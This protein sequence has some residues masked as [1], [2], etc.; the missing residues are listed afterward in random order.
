MLPRPPR[1]FLRPFV[2]LGLLLLVSVPLAQAQVVIKERV[3]IAPLRKGHALPDSL[4]N[5]LA[6]GEAVTAIIV[7]PKDG[8]LQLFYTNAERI[9]SP[10]PDSAFVTVLRNGEVMATDPVLTRFPSV[11]QAPRF[12]NTCFGFF[13]VDLFSYTSGANALFDIGEVEEGDVLN[14]LYTSGLGTFAGFAIQLNETT[15]N[16]D[17]GDFDPCLRTWTER[18]SFGVAVAIEKLTIEI[19]EPKEVWPEIPDG[20]AYRTFD[21]DAVEDMIEEVVIE[22]TDGN[23]PLPMQE[24]TVTAD[25]IVGTG[26][27]DHNNAPAQEELGTF[28]VINPVPPFA[29]EGDGTIL[30]RSDADGLVRLRYT[31][32]IFGGQVVLRVT[33]TIDGEDFVARDTL[34]V[35][36]P[37]LALLANPGTNYDN[38]GGTCDHHGPRLDAAFPTC[39][40]PDNNHAA[41]A[42]V[43]GNLEDIADGWAAEEA[44]QSPLRINDLSLPQGGKF[45]VTGQWRGDHT[46]HRVGR[47]ADIRT[48]RDLTQRTGVLLTLELDA[49]GNPVTDL[50]G[51]QSFTNSDFEDLCADNGA[52]PEP[53]VHSP[54]TNNEHY[55][56]FFYPEN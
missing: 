11:V 5:A 54:G 6:K 50:Q 29:T 16:V 9:F 28:E 34:T 30:T 4:A 38:V 52:F 20:G 19:P 43:V 42:D 17:L 27:H 44:D 25:W 32:P 23:D 8:R 39:R 47:D 35:R 45:D 55:H 31:A 7:A 13:T 3:E 41:L 14:F 46:F 1:C 2:L 56:V 15:W 49:E 21:F 37:D 22:V 53:E 18:V 10:I 48:T 40:T 24:V 33:S 12:L 51:R 36:V 26:G